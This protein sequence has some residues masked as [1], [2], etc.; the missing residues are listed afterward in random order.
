MSNVTRNYNESIERQISRFRRVV[1][2]SGKLKQVRA[3]RY[4]K[5]QPSKLMMRAKAQYRTQKR[6]E[7]MEG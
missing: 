4:F 5:S 1:L 6:E 3:S 2:R 7:I